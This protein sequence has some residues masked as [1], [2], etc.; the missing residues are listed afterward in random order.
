MDEDIDDLDWKDFDKKFTFQLEY[1]VQTIGRRFLSD[2]AIVLEV[3]SDY[4]VG[5]TEHHTM[6][7]I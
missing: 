6:G 4:E 7:D 1:L 5:D 3:H 2:L